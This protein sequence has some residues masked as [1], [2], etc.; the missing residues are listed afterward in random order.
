[1]AAGSSSDPSTWREL[2]ETVP[3][4]L[5]AYL[6]GTLHVT[7]QVASLSGQS[8]QVEFNWNHGEDFW[9]VCNLFSQIRRRLPTTAEAGR[10]TPHLKL[11]CGETVLEMEQIWEGFPLASASIRKFLFDRQLLPVGQS[12]VCISLTAIYGQ[13]TGP[14]LAW[15]ER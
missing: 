11:V 9:T 12:E 2:P 10:R 15:D 1:M 3:W 5:P 14:H 13:T 8:V 4:K 7:F 6:E